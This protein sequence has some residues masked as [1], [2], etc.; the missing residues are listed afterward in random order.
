MGTIDNST[1]FFKLTTFT[2]WIKAEGDTGRIA[3][4]DGFVF[5]EMDGGAS[6]RGIALYERYSLSAVITQPEGL[7]LYAISLLDG[8]ERNGSKADGDKCISD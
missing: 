4:G 5:G 3:N 7:F 1:H 6:A 2:L 8:A